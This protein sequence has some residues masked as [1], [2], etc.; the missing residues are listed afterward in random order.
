MADALI[1]SD[2]SGHKYGDGGRAAGR[3][4]AGVPLGVLRSLSADQPVL[5]DAV[6]CGSSE[7]QCECVVS[8]SS[9]A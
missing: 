6:R 9:P 7:C 1:S 5:L 4:A 2:A 3:A 8:P